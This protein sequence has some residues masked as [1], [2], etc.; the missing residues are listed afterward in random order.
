[1]KIRVLRSGS[2]GNA[3]WIA[4]GGSAVL[5]DAGLAAEALLRVLSET[6]DETPLQAILLTHE[7]DDHARGAASL[8]RTLEIPVLANEGTIR[9]AGA[10]LAGAQVERFSTSRPFRVGGLTVEAFPVPHDAAEPVGFVLSG[11]AAQA[12]VVTDL[13]EATDEVRER[14]AEA[15]ALLVEANY[16]LALL[17][18]SPYPWFLKNRILSPVGHLSND[19]AARVALAAAAG[20][21][22]TVALLHLSDINN[23]T[24]LARDTVQWTL[25]QH[26]LTHVRVE[27]VRANGTGPL[28]VV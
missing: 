2:S 21:A 19:A 26:G 7:H 3:V 18:V 28:W 9:A 11:N 12:C 16:D 6:A 8:A 5:I 20:R 15:D 23:L 1:M 24:P 4:S 25:A 22:R 17:G 14:A 13:G 27:A 10:L